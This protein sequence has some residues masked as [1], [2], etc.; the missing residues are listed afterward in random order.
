V[1]TA[2]A[3]L[4]PEATLERGFSLSEVSSISQSQSYVIVY[5]SAEVIV[6]QIVTHLFTLGDG[7]ET[8][9]H[10]VSFTVIRTVQPFW[11]L[12]VIY[13]TVYSRVTVQINLALETTPPAGNSNGLIIGVTTGVGVIAALTLGI[14]IWLVRAGRDES[15]S[16]ADDRPSF[17]R[18]ESRTTTLGS[19]TTRGSSSDDDGIAIIGL[20]NTLTTETLEGLDVFVGS[21]EGGDL[22]I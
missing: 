1:F 13:V 8:V 21:V 9:S 11:S 18:T 6:S 16:E 17:D 7:A 2:A 12:G 20:Q 22:W 14:G 19:S 5:S 15:R 3:T 10:T 4:T